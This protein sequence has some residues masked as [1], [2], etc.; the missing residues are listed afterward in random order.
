MAGETEYAFWHALVRDV[1]YGAL[2][3]AA[4]ASRH[5]ATA[6]WIEA[7][8]GDRVEDVADVLAHHYS[9]ALNLARAM[10]DGQSSEL[11]APALRFLLLAGERTLELDV[12]AATGLLDEALELAPPGHPE[13]PRVLRRYGAAMNASGRAAMPLR[14]YEEA[15]AGF[16]AA[17]DVRA[18]ADVLG[19]LSSTFR[20][21]GDARGWTYPHEV[22]DLLEGLGPSWELA[23]A[24]IRLGFVLSA[25]GRLEES[26]ATLGR[27][28]TVAARIADPR[29]ADAMAFRGNLLA[30]RGLVGAMLGDERGLDEMEEA[31]RLSIASGNSNRAGH[32]YSNLAQQVAMWRGPRAGVEVLKK[33]LAFAAGRGL[34]AHVAYQRVFELFCEFDLGEHDAVLDGS[35]VLERA[36]ESS[37]W[38]SALVHVRSYGVLR[39]DVAREAGGRR[40]ARLDRG[41]CP[42]V[43]RAGRP[44][45]AGR[46]RARPP[47]P[48]RTRCSAGSAHRAGPAHGGPVMRGGGSLGR[49][50]RW[51]ARPW[52]SMSSG[53]PNPWWAASTRRIRTLSTRPSPRMPPSSRPAVTWPRR[54]QPTVMRPTD[55]RASRSSRSWRSP[56]WAREGAWSRAVAPAEAAEP[57]ARARSIFERLKAAPALAEIAEL[58]N[59]AAP[60]GT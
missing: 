1:A 31:V 5:V 33:G 45:G 19:T 52:S 24:L 51:C 6:R 3:R 59:G 16:R 53:W 40:D 37:G 55:G 46:D 44:P 57:L 29:A 17:G 28:E 27:A 12:A 60:T 26:L 11:E 36:V 14:R 41:S 32:T 30:V 35:P 25:E 42:G 15:L 7:Q 23:D 9:T 2:P 8:A 34:Q 21:I 49:S 38:A 39:L 22:V 56:C 13:R 4:R 20:D 48:W 54:S 58:S 10:G 50:R 47:A 18:S 43:E